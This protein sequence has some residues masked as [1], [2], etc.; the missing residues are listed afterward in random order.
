MKHFV[1]TSRLGLVLAL[2]TA[3]AAAV[4]FA[5][6]NANPPP[7]AQAQAA[8]Q[9][10]IKTVPKPGKGLMV[11]TPDFG[12][13][14]SGLSQPL[15]RGRPK[16]WAVIDVTYETKSPTKWT[17]NVYVTFY[18][19]TEGMTP[20]R[21]KELGFYTLRVQYVNVSDGEHRAGVVLHPSTL[22]R[23]GQNGVVA[24]ACEITAD[25][26]DKPEVKSEHT[27]SDL[28]QFKDDWWKNDR[29]LNAEIVKKRDGLLERSKTPFGLIYV[30][31]YEAVR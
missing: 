28:N 13:R 4:V 15:S 6:R 1:P 23:F 21:K 29:I 2:A 19:M 25:G 31:D 5:Q 16:E 10:K 8:T 12:A 17:D 24:I 7:P 20:D 14:A 11:S 26:V 3:G 30:D 27:L 18:V 22:E 9:V